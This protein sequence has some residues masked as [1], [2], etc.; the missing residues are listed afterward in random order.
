MNAYP[1]VLH[2]SGKCCVVIGG[3]RVATRKVESLLLSMADIIVISPQITAK[4]EV[5]H[6][7]KQ[8]QVHLKVYQQGMLEALRPFLVFAATN[9]PDVNHQ[10]C[11]EAHQLGILVNRVDD[12][13]DS[14]FSNMATFHHGKI[15]IGVS[16]SGASPL[17]SVYLKEH[18]QQIIGPE[19]AILADWLEQSR[20]ML[21]NITIETSRHRTFWHQMLDSRLLERL[22]HGQL[23]EARDIFECFLRAL[24]EEAQ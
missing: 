21:R 19:Y 24:L 15:T 20:P 2:L 1:I 17:L 23:D 11:E 7:Q 13:D 8:L 10:I 9:M 4:L 18:L 3:G 5:F 14:D 6:Q 22:R 16:T 12:H